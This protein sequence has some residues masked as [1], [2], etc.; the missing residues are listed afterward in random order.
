MSPVIFRKK[1]KILN[2]ELFQR[3]TKTFME[4]FIQGKVLFPDQFKYLC[5]CLCTYK[6]TY[7]DLGIFNGH[8]SKIY[9]QEEEQYVDHFKYK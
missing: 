7:N 3:F 9:I 4:I 5:E 8:F 1:G 6:R 2:T